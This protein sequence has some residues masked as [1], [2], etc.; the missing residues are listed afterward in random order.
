MDS[1]ESRTVQPQPFL[2]GARQSAPFHTVCIT[3]EV[4]FVPSGPARKLGSLEADHQPVC[5]GGSRAPRPVLSPHSRQQHGRSETEEYSSD[6]ESESEDED[7]L[8]LILQDLQRQNEELEVRMR[9]AAALG[10]AGVHVVL[11]GLAPHLTRGLWAWAAVAPSGRGSNT[12]ENPTRDAPPGVA[13][14][15]AI[16]GSGR[17]ASGSSSL[18]PS[19][20]IVLVLSR[21]TPAGRR[22]PPGFTEGEGPCPEGGRPA[23]GGQWL[24]VFLGSQLLLDRLLRLSLQIKNN[25]LNQAIHEEREAIIELRVQL[26]LLQLQRARPEPLAE[27]EPG[28]REPP[29]PTKEQARPSPGRE[30]KE[31]PI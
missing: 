9:R 17:Q 14:L 20:Q 6:S 8:Q 4:G 3:S 13:G 24:S 2:D 19:L 30:R 21:K 29:P 15:R 22:E 16:W 12:T 7:E 23:G 28:A 11:I 31:T 18:C 5:A 26:R 27:P 10:S 25:H 1:G